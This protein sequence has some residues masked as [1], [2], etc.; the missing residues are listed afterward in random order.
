MDA[1]S[2]ADDDI[3]GLWDSFPFEYGSMEASQLGLLSDGTGWGSWSNFGGAMELVRLTWSRPGPGALEMVELDV[4]SGRWE[5]EHPDRIF[6]A[7]PPNAL[8]ATRRYRYRL[9]S[10]VPPLGDQ[11]VRALKLDRPF[12][13]TSD[14]AFVRNTIT[15]ADVPVV[16]DDVRPEAA[17][18]G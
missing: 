2:S 16:V 7:R 5:A 11:P 12:L 4:V 13:F 18:P 17:P 1:R 15:A 8:N 14:F 3:V 10:E 6:S 9:T